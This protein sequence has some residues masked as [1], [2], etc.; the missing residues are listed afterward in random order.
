MNR[1]D[2]LHYY[3]DL[4]GEKVI[5]PMNPLTAYQ[6]EIEHCTKCSLSNSRH[7][8]VFG[9]GN[10]N[11]PIMFVGEAPGEQEDLQGIPFIG[12]AGQLLD[13]LLQE[14]GLQRSD[15]FIANVLKCRPPANRDPL[16]EEIALCEPYLHQQI[17]LIQPNVIV[18]LGRIA[19]KTLLKQEMALKDMRGK[20]LQYQ[21]VDL[22]VTY[23]PAAILRN[24][25]NL[26]LIQDDFLILKEK[27]WT[28]R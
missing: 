14:I 26:K 19:G 28:K 18:A 13:K 3:R 15:I 1:L 9:N 7:H 2:W 5:F 12:R 21:G 10:P 16:P 27:Y 22:M 20:K 8:F 4:F 6:K 24:M 23:H 17:R 25:N 11:A